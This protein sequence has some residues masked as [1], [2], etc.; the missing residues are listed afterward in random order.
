MVSKFDGTSQEGNH[1]T[2]DSISVSQYQDHGINI[3]FNGS[4]KIINRNYKKGRKYFYNAIEIIYFY[5]RTKTEEIKYDRFDLAAEESSRKTSHLLDS[6]D[7]EIIRYDKQ[8][9]Q[10]ELNSTQDL[11]NSLLVEVI[12]IGYGR[13]RLLS[14]PFSELYI[15]PKISVK[16]LKREIEKHVKKRSHYIVSEKLKKTKIGN[17]NGLKWRIQIGGKT[18][19]DH[20]IFF[21]NDYDYLF[22]SSPYGSNGTVENII[23]KME[24]TKT[25]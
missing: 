5:E 4:I 18:R 19:L 11:I 17:N 1:I 8:G 6:L 13:Q 15:M 21:G 23:S 10:T 24:L 16:K 22:V 20:Y 3:F 12:V 9:L 25:K 2:S 7:K 14:E